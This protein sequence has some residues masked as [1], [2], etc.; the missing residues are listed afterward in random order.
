MQK[1]IEIK[2]GLQFR[3]KWLKAL[4]TVIKVSEKTNLLHVSIDPQE[5]G[6]HVWEETEWNLQHTI[7]GFESGDYYIE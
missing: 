6:R 3:S 7:W 5:E 2:E 4:I 1:E